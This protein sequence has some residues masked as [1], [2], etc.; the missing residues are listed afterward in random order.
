MLWQESKPIRY[1]KAITTLSSYM[2]KPH[3]PLTTPGLPQPK[4]TLPSAGELIKK[5]LLF[6]KAHW[7]TIIGIAIPPLI[8]VVFAFLFGQNSPMFIVFGGAAGIAALFAR[9]ALFIFVIKEGAEKSVTGAYRDGLRMFFPFVWIIILLLLTTFGG[10]ILFVI[11]GILLAVWLSVSVFSLFSENKR[12]IDALALS[13]HYTKGYWMSVA[14]R[15]FVFAVFAWI[16]AAIFFAPLFLLTNDTD[17][18]NRFQVLNTIADILFFA[19]LSAIYSYLIYQSL[20]KAK[21]G[22]SFEKDR[23]NLRKRII[24]FI[25]LGI[26]GILALIAIVGFILFAVILAMFGYFHQDSL[27]PASF[28]SALGFSPFFQM[29]LK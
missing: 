28:I 24:I 20:K 1:N 27:A 18:Q 19:P 23:P 2:N 25:I 15:F 13:W 26:V 16:V 7:K 5:T 14:W 8:L 17:A 4:A 3:T 6:Y 22:V 9:L 10:I 21:E 11:P 12:G 29:I